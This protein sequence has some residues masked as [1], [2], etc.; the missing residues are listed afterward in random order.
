MPKGYVIDFMVFY[1]LHSEWVSE[2]NQLL[3]GFI[4]KYKLKSTHNYL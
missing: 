3:V 1:V 2:A 4:A